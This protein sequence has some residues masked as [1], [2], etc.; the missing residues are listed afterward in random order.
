[1]KTLRKVGQVTFK[2]YPI[3][4]STLL[5]TLADHLLQKTHYCNLHYF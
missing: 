2:R 3:S 4:F 1:M 5:G